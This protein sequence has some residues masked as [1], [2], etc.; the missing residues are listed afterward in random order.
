MLNA[1]WNLKSKYLAGGVTLSLG[2]FAAIAV[3]PT[4][5]HGENRQPLVMKNAVIGV[6]CGQGSSGAKDPSEANQRAQE[7]LQDR[8]SDKNDIDIKGELATGQDIITELYGPFQ[9]STQTLESF[10]DSKSQCSENQTEV[11]VTVV[12]TGALAQPKN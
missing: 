2:L 5:A 8:L 10:N 9:I 4:S 12:A 1:N 7:E 6:V 11:C 3:S